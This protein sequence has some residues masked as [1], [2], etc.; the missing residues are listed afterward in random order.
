[1]RSWASLSPGDNGHV[2]SC[3][4]PMA[5]CRELLVALRDKVEEVSVA[6]TVA[7]ELE[8]FANHNSWPPAGRC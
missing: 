2:R 8:A 4:T 5:S 1:M 6:L 7:K 3:V